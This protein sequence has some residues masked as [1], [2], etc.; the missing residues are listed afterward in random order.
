MDFCDF[1]N[2]QFLFFFQI[3]ALEQKILFCDQSITTVLH[4]ICSPDYRTA[5]GS[6][7]L[8]QACPIFSAWPSCTCAGLMF[9]TTNLFSLLF[10]MT[11]HISPLF[12]TSLIIVLTDQ[13]LITTDVKTN[14]GSP[15]IWMTNRFAPLFSTTVDHWPRNQSYCHS[16]PWP[17]TD[18]HPFQRPI[19]DHQ[20]LFWRHCIVKY[21]NS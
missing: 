16:S 3:R 14:H 18:H 20:L 4:S 2:C 11:N 17:I 21:L 15:L 13:S 1:F 5:A 12:W 6:W 9:P 10:S 7:N 8:E 19:T